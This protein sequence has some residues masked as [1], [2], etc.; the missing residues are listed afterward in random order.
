MDILTERFDL[1]RSLDKM[2]DLVVLIDLEHP[3]EALSAGLCFEIVHPDQV[4]SA[5]DPK[6]KTFLCRSS[7]QGGP[8]DKTLD[9]IYD[10]SST[11]LHDHAGILAGKVYVARDITFRKKC[12]Q[13]ME[14]NLA[15]GEYALNHQLTDILR[16]TIDKAEQLTG[17]KIGF[18]HFLNSLEGSVTVQAW[19]TNTMKHFCTA[20]IANAHY[21]IENAGVWVDSYYEKCPVVHND[22]ASLK[23][24]K[25]TP[26][27]HAELRRE[28]TVPIIRNDQVVA[29]LGIGNKPTPYTDQDVALVSQLTNLAY[30]FAESR[31]FEEALHKSEQYARALLDAIPD[32]IFRMT[33]EGNY[34][35]YKG[36]TEDLY[37]QESTI[38]GKNNR[39]LS[40]PDFASLIEEKIKLALETGGMVNFEYRLPVN[41]K[42]MRDFE[43][44]M[45]PSGPDEVTA[46]ARDITERKTTELA[47]KKKIG[48]LEWF[49]RLMID[50]E[51]KMIEL[52]Q[53]VNMLSKRLGEPE[54]YIIHRI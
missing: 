13:V 5:S 53:E 17:S 39:D 9:G 6:A 42:G 16:I 33:R 19:S 4:Q 20:E 54:T 15:L 45:A 51:V 30:E 25:G 31:R 29:I 43:A 38:I 1:L 34:L 36:I 27:G 26:E 28:L 14:A 50:R 7:D 18:F 2:E 44:R 3:A 48:E 46:I 35:D 40:P 52:K 49:N 10:I 8:V 11:E 12:E 22:F 23:H 24:R 37:Y 21:P 32:L 47:L 41:G